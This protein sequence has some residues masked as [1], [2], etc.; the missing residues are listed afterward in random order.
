MS[1]T[2]E[3]LDSYQGTLKVDA[4]LLGA[5]IDAITDCAQL[6]SAPQPPRSLA[7]PRNT[8]PTSPGRC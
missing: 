5:A 2:S 7:A 3:L 1:Y 8:T 4:A 6:T